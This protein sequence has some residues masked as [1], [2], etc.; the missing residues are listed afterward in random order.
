MKELKSGVYL[1]DKLEYRGTSMIYRINK[2]DL[3][4]K[5]SN[6]SF[7]ISISP[8]AGKFLMAIRND[9]KE[10]SK[11]QKYWITN[12]NHI[13]ISSSNPMFNKNTDY[14][15]KVWPIIGKKN[16]NKP[17]SS[18]KHTTTKK[19]TKNHKEISELNHMINS[20]DNYMTTLDDGKNDPSESAEV[21]TANKL[22]DQIEHEIK[23]KSKIDFL[24]S[25]RYV[26]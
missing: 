18:K 23:K 11:N 16:S 19:T 7:S 24:Y 14:T 20:L 13:L 6:D 5:E 21:K 17:K 10:P 22:T 1:T 12:E 15:I 9:G 26:N 4:L 2:E 8:I 3:S 25:I